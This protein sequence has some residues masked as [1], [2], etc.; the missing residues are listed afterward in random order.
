MTSIL[1]IPARPEAP[2][3][4]DMTSASDTPEER[5]LEYGRLFERA[6]ASRERRADSVV[7]AFRGGDDIRAW[8]DGL[9]RR[10]AACCPFLDYHVENVGDQVIWTTSNVVTGR[11]RA[12]V[13]AVLDA[14][15]ELADHAGS[16]IAGSLDRL[17]R[18]VQ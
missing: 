13:D 9:V 16:D 1:H 6:L 15:Y 8:V 3:A 5:L 7:L 14:L 17:A 12:G 11:D 2:V 4:C 18:S 10:E